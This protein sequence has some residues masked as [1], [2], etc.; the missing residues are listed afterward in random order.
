M[1][2]TPIAIAAIMATVEP[3]NISVLSP[4]VVVCVAPVSAADGASVTSKAVCAAE[5]QYDSS[6]AKLARIV[7]VPV[8]GGVQ[9]VLKCPMLSVVT[10]PIYCMFPFGSTPI[11]HN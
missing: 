7:Y 3:T 6:P 8:T 9:A 11:K 1:S 10:V 5:L 2:N 4:V